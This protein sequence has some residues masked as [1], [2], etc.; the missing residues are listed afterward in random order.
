MAN[1]LSYSLGFKNWKQEPAGS[2]VYTKVENGTDV[3]ISNLITS[4]FS[5]EL[6]WAPHEQFY[7]GKVYRIPIINKYPI[8]TLRFIAGVKGIWN[9]QYN[10]QNVSARFE[11]RAYMSQLGYSDLIVEGGYI[12]GKLPYP[13]MTIH[14]ANQTY[15]YQL[16]SYNLMNFQEFVS[17]HFAAVS[18]DHH[19]NGLFFNRIPLLKKLKLREVFSVKMLWGG[20]RDENKPSKD[21]SLIKYP[22]FEGVPTTFSLEK[23]PYVEGSVGIANIFKLLRVDLVQRFNY[24][25]NPFVAR[26]GVR[27]RFKFD[28]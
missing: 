9:S 16:N 12:F 22:T 11:K 13:L 7:Q 6:R 23:K 28:F 20:V 2:I 21:P 15:A 1:H 26:I 4:E 19:F 25:D 24:L 18:I 10:Y 3:N 14:R 17:D 8:F 27:A 5:A